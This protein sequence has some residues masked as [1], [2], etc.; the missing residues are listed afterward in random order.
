MKGLRGISVLTL[1]LL[2]ALPAAPVMAEDENSSE[3]LVDASLVPVVFISSP[4]IMSI[5]I[6]MI[7]NE[8]ERSKQEHSKP[9]R[10]QNRRS[11]NNNLPDMQVTRVAQDENGNPRVH[12]QI[13]EQPEHS[14]TLTWPKSAHNPTAAFHEGSMVS[15]KPSPQGAGWLL[16]DESETALAFMP[17]QVNTAANHSALF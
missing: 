16:H 2:I 9:Y 3:V 8:S 6:S 5:I 15:F 10:A 13:P 7:E 1:A 4:F 14:I 12:L 11:A 17:L